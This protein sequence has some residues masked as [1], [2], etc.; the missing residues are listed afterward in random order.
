VFCISGL[1]ADE[2]IFNNLKI[3]GIQL[4]FIKWVQPLPTETIKEY[5]H[6]LCEQLPAQDPII[7]GV[8]FGGMMAIEIAKQKPVSKIVLIS[9]VKTH[10]EVPQWMKNCGNYQLDRILPA[11]QSGYRALKVMRPIQNYF[12]GAVTPEEKKIVNEYRDNVDPVYIRWAIRQV[13]C[14][15]NDWLPD[16]L[17]HLHGEK[18]HI[19]PVKKVKAA[20]V[21]PQAGHF[22]IMN[23]CKQIVDILKDEI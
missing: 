15:K 7:L 19:F 20:H 1:G 8:S 4:Q 14:W 16:N 23:R 21:I 6:R 12:L 9:S 3:P 11:R 22:M 18:D 13:L 2:R 10:H 17:V 5:A